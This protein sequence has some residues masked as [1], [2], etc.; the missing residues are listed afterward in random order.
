MMTRLTKHDV[1][2]QRA[3]R[4]ASR[5]F[6]Y[7]EALDAKELTDGYY[8]SALNWKEFGE[9]QTITVSVVAGDTLNNEQEVP[10]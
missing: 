2:L 10:C 6:V 5:W 1:V 7:F 8:M 9:P 4:Q 3:S